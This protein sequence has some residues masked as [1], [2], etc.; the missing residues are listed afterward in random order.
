K[1]LT[2]KT[3]FERKAKEMLLSMNV[4]KNLSKD[5][6]IDSYLNVVSFGRNSNGS[7]I[8]GIESAAQGVFGKSAKNLNV[9]QSA[10]LAGLPQNP[11]TYTPCL[12]TAHLKKDQSLQI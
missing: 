8:A 3:S 6:I 10:Y 5:G 7:N 1:L 9:A 4:E 11:Y 2:N 12:P